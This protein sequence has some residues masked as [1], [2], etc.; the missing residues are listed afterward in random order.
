[1]KRENVKKTVKITERGVTESGQAVVF[2]YEK[3][4]GEK[5]QVCQFTAFEDEESQ[6][7]VLSGEVRLE[8]KS[9]NAFFN[10]KVQAG[11]LS[12]VAEILQEVEVICELEK[13]KNKEA[14]DEVESK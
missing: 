4:T 12:L 9:L 6:K 1:M 11:G 5:V 10:E 7:I 8:Q 13:A 2:I 14:S 3:T